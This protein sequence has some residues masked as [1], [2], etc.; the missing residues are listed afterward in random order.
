MSI[1]LRIVKQLNF[2]M[3]C[4]TVSVDLTSSILRKQLS[5]TYW[6]DPTI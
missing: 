2:A 1:K 6:R 4:R 3:H 5:T